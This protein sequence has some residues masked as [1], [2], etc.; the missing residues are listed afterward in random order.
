MRK[1]DMS[2]SKVLENL[3]T[4]AH[5]AG[6]AM[7]GSED[8]FNL[9]DFSPADV[10]VAGAKPRTASGKANMAA[11]QARTWL[12]QMATV[13]PSLSIGSGWSPWKATA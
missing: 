1:V 11:E 6:Y 2:M 12:R 7:V 9:A 5:A 3:D 10:S 8:N 4:A 13:K